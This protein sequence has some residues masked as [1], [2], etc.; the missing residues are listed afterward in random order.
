MQTKHLLISLA[1]AL[2]NAQTLSEI[3]A[4]NPPNLSTLISLLEQQP[5]LVKTLAGL[6]DITILAPNDDAFETLLADPAAAARVQNEP[7]FVPALLTYHVLNG[8][9]YAA[10]FVGATETLF[11]PT[12][13]TDEKYTTVSGGQ[14]VSARVEDGEVIVASGNG[15]EATVIAADTNFTAGTIHVIDSV[16]SIPSNLT[17]TLI[18]NDLTALAEAASSADLVET[19]TGIPQLTIFA[20]N[21]DAFEAIKDVAADL[22]VEELTGVL[23][24]HVIGGAVV[25]SVDVEDGAKAKT[26]QGGELTFSVR[27]GGVFVNDKQVVKADV[28]IA[29]GVVHVIDGVLIPDGDDATST[30]SGTPSETSPVTGKA[31]GMHSAAFGLTMLVGGLAVMW[32]L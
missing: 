8:T 19:L 3:L 10:D 14:R 22:S 12:L 18:D 30:T 20:P 26:V 1:A 24:Y 4:S 21:N 25:Y 7:G 17:T 5:E 31:A 13:L 27:D 29:N 32:N 9:F 11:A 16:L 2:A 23:G 6:Q 15:A 28:L